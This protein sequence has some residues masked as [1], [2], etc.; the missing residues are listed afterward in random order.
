MT[1]PHRHA[2]AHF[3]ATWHPISEG[4]DPPD[5]WGWCFVDEVMVELPD[6]TLQVGP[7]PKFV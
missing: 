2:T 7:I 5:G 6:Q 4:Y 3:H 1:P